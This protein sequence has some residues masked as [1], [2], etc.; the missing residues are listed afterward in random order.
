[1]AKNGKNSKNGKSDDEDDKVIDIRGYKA[2]EGTT[3]TQRAAHSLDWCAKTHPKVWISPQLLVQAMYGY[4]RLPPLK[5]NEVKQLLRSRHTIRAF[6]QRDYNR[7]LA[8]LRGRGL[9]ATVDAADALATVVAA[10]HGRF[11]SASENFERSAQ[12]AE[13]AETHIKDPGLKS[14]N[15]RVQG[16]VKQL[17]TPS[18]KNRLLP[19]TTDDEES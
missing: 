11:R 4:S 6:L 9:R 14:F 10:S 19:V 12:L 13:G 1:M 2:P 17:Q 16:L 8:S 18:F 7:G 3:L 15:D 5:S